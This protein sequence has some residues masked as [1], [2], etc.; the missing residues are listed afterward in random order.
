MQQPGNTWLEAWQMA[1]PLPVQRQKKLFDHTSE[2]EKVVVY[3]QLNCCHG[4]I[5]VLHYMES[6]RP[7]ELSLQ[8]LP[9]LLIMGVDMIKCKLKEELD[10]ES[11]LKCVHN[12]LAD[13]VQFMSSIQHRPSLDEL[14]KLQV[15]METTYFT[16]LLLP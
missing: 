5:Q 4:Y 6:V 15:T 8:L 16:S 3:C 11:S 1:E 14:P 10:E 7:V 13:C 9:S 12:L 2:A